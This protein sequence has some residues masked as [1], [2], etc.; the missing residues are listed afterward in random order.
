[1]K[2]TIIALLALLA[3][4]CGKEDEHKSPNE[5]IGMGDSVR[6]IIAEH[7]GISAD[8]IRDE[9]TFASLYADDLD[10]VEVTMAIEYAHGIVIRDDSLTVAAG[11]ANT[12]QLVARLTVGTL[13]SVAASSE[14]KPPPKPGEENLPV[15][16]YANLTKLNLST[17]QAV[18]IVPSL[19][20]VLALSEADA[21][22]PLT[23]SEVLAIRDRSPAIALPLSVIEEMAESRGYSDIAPEHC[24]EQWQE[25]RKEL[26]KETTDQS[27]RRV[28]K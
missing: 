12:D 1:M 5:P 9:A 23:Q 22:R 25:M 8:E 11:A 16:A 7:L 14:K 3:F 2:T 26:Q 20:A 13:I 18:C 27:S 28:S 17:N 21:G 19:A 4:G 6:G 10:L 24:W 15:G